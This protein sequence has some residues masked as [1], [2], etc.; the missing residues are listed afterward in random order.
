[1]CVCAHA[2]MLHK[3]PGGKIFYYKG[4]QNQWAS[5]FSFVNQIDRRQGNTACSFL[6][7]KEHDLIIL[8]PT[9]YSL[10]NAENRKTFLCN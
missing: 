6:R 8:C 5:K 3:Y 2:F 7:G 4:T 10:I 1:M 9:E